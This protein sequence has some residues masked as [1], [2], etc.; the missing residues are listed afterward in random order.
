MPIV[1]MTTYPC[2]WCGTKTGVFVCDDCNKHT[3]SECKLASTEAGC[4][5]KQRSIVTSQDWK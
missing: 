5:H 1:D 2:K 3:C 4:V